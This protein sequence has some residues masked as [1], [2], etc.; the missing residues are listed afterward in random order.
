MIQPKSEI[1]SVFM[2]NANG[3]NTGRYAQ[4]AYRIMAP[5]IE[6]AKDSGSYEENFD[7]KFIKYIGIYDYY[8]WGGEIA[9]IKWK[10]ELAMVYLPSSYPIDGLEKLKHAE[11]NTFNRIRSDGELGDEIIFKV[12]DNGEVESMFEHS[13]YWPKFR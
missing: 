10:G 1:A 5:A 13:N 7:S 9:V 2:A 3:I 8:P 12:G 6:A 11:G 4:N